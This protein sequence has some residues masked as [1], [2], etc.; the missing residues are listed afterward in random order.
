MS[1]VYKK[2]CFEFT[3]MNVQSCIVLILTKI[4]FFRID[5]C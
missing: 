3:H 4:I 1:N 5:Y 2:L